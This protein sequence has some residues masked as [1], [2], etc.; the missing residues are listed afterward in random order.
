MRVIIC[1]VAVIITSA[2]ATPI[3]QTGVFSPPLYVCALRWWNETYFCSSQNCRCEKLVG[4][5]EQAVQPL[6]REAKGSELLGPNVCV[7]T[8]RDI[9]T[10]L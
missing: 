8:T 1:L 6:C 4:K 9:I 10:Y 3:P 5:I 2:S 7:I